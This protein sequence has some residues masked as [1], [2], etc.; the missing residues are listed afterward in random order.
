MPLNLEIKARL[1]N[2]NSAI[3]IARWIQAD[4]VGTLLQKDT[5]Y[6]VPHGRL[7]LRQI[8]GDRSELI[9]YQRAENSNQRKSDFHILEICDPAGTKKFLSRALPVIGV[10]S[11]KRI[12]FLIDGTRIHIDEVRGLGCFLE[13][14]VPIKSTLAGARK[15]L[16]ELIKKFGIK[17]KD[18]IKNSYINCLIEKKG[19]N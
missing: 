18:F 6:R 14:E 1:T 13:F 17:K 15:R 7:K 9:F 19:A 2:V 16:N 11:K 8:K 5:Y 12:L 4:R 3:R 10:V